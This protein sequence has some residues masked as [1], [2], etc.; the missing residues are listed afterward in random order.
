MGRE[1]LGEFEQVVLLA[2]LRLGE[3]AYTMA[4]ADEIER[5]TA[6]EVSHAAVY[7]ALRRMEEKS[8][9]TSCLGDATP[10]RG[11]RPKRF[12]TLLPAGLRALSESRNALMSLWQGLHDPVDGAFRA[13]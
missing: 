11:G 1:W 5:V 8:L 3:D 7:V 12:F 2:S 6:R 10:A 13:P 4:I 9:V